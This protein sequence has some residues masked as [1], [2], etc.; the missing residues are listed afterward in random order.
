MMK[1]Y[2]VGSV[3][4]SLS[5]FLTG[6]FPARSE[7]GRLLHEHA[8]SVS[9]LRIGLDNRK[10]SIPLVKISQIKRGKPPPNNVVILMV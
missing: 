1:D 4:G 6:I 5:L 8:G 3:R 2:S 7:R 9:T 10:T